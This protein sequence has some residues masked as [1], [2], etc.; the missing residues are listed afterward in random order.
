MSAPPSDAERLYR[1]LLDHYGP[2]DW[3]PARTPFEVCVG[4]ILTQ[5][6][7]WKNVQKAI[8]N[9][10]AAGCLSLQSINTLPAEKLAEL[11]RPAGYYNIKSRRLQNL[12][13]FLQQRYHGSL[14]QLFA[15]DWQLTRKELLELNGIGPET[16]D[17]ILLYAGN[18]PTFVVDSYT[19]R[20]FSRLGLVD[21]DIG[22]EPLRCWFMAQLPPNPALFN[23]YHALIVQHAKD[24]CRSRPFCD[25]CPFRTDCAAVDAA[26]ASVI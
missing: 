24:H 17:S 21:P 19:R 18:L 16:A 2:M 3:W 14:E 13:G 6:T 4:A 20:I 22:Y 15:R 10:D 5:N 8:A 25:S 26:S 1:Q 7:N 11:I 12:T 9:L 23:E